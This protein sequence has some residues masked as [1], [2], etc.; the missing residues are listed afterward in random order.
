M[1]WR[2]RHTTLTLCTLAFFA[3]MVARLSIS[4]VVPD[5][6]GQL[7]VSNGMIGLA[8]S[9]MWAGYA[10]TQFPSGMLG[11]RFGYRAVILVA[12]GGTAV[13][14]ASLAI[15]PSYPFFLAATIL[16]GIATGLHYSPATTF[17]TRQFENTGRAI[18][19]HV[20]GGPIAGLLAPV[21][22][23]FVGVRY[24][25]RAAV[26]LGVVVAVPIF[27]AFLFVVRPTRP[28]HPEQSIRN[29]LE[30][31]TLRD[32][33][34]RREIAYTTGLSVIGAFS[35]QATASF[36]PAFLEAHQG[37]SGTTA[38]LLFAGYFLV[39]GVTQPGLGMAS[40]RFSRESVV[41]TAWTFGV[42]GYA[43]LILAGDIVGV[44]AGVFCVGI[45][46]G[47]GAPLQSRFMDVLAEDE[48]GMG[49]GLVRT[50]YMTM[51][52]SGSVV[53]GAVSDSSGWPIAFGILCVLL[54][55]GLI[56]I[57]ANRL[58]ALDL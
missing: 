31:T 10:M 4:P 35:W 32:L 17:L 41:F 24:G 16:L 30:L 56:A 12:V 2:Y 1:A 42:I 20:T 6:T 47:W 18:G 36:L 49:F 28:A 38:G 11:D 58:L 23:T 44:V 7:G 8:L 46:M 19:I 55:L 45:A 39:H 14:S 48:Q 21:A 22:A 37:F 51:G 33:L 53:V 9:G 15:A 57:G 54:T 3:T 40:D 29:R 13:T 34:S 5:I 26:A 52:A 25:W 27:V 43:T 50:T